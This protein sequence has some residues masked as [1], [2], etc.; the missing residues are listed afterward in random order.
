MRLKSRNVS[1]NTTVFL[2]LKIQGGKY[3]QFLS[4]SVQ[5]LSAYCEKQKNGGFWW[6]SAL[7]DDHENHYFLFSQKADKSYTEILRNYCCFQNCHWIIIRIKTEVMRAK[8]RLFEPV[9][10][11]NPSSNF[12]HQYLRNRLTQNLP[13]EGQGTGG[14]SIHHE[15]AG[16]KFFSFFRYS[17][18]VVWHNVKYGEPPYRLRCFLARTSVQVPV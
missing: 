13:P 17:S 1:P 6:A 9:N 14:S 18:P 7:F 15:V 8:I 5:L 12:Y 11:E 16:F 4:I 10:L 3:Q 2:R